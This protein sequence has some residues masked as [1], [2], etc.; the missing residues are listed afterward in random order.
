[1]FRLGGR[2]GGD[3]SSFAVLHGLYWLTVN[4]TAHSPW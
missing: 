4:A 2:P 1:M 3:D